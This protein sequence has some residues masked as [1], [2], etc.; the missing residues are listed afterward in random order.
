MSRGLC[1][2]TPEVWERFLPAFKK[3]DQEEIASAPFAK[4]GFSTL[5]DAIGTPAKK[6]VQRG[7]SLGRKIGQKMDKRLAK[8]INFKQPL[9]SA[10]KNTPI[11]TFEKNTGEAKP[12][13]ISEVMDALNLMLQNIGVSMEN[14]CQIVAGVT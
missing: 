1:R 10:R 4:R 6:P 3:Q 2:A 9:V 11:Y 13:N 12:Q 5:L 14:F 7:H 8:P